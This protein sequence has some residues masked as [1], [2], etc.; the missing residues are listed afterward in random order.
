LK[1]ALDDVDRQWRIYSNR[2]AMAGTAERPVTTQ[3]EI[4]T[5]PSPICGKGAEE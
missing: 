1:L 4:R 3:S 5:A 2:A